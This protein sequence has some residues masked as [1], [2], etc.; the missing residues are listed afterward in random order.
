M[1][2]KCGDLI[3]N[4]N[5]GNNI[6]IPKNT[7]KFLVNDN[8]NADINY[9]INI[10]DKISIDNKIS[11]KRKDLIICKNEE[12]N[13]ETRYLL[14]PNYFIP[15][16]SYVELDENNIKINFVKDF[17]DK[18]SIDNLFWSLFALER[19][20][21]KNNSIILHCS[22]IV[23]KNHAILFS[24]PSGIGKSTQANLWKEYNNCKIIN[25]DRCILTKKNN[26]WYVR[27]L[28]IC[29]SSQ[30]CLN[31]EYKLGNIIFLKQDF[32]N[33][34]TNLNKPNAIKNL[35]NQ[36]TINYWDNQFVSKSIEFATSISNEHNIYE[37]RCTPDINAVKILKNTLERNEKWIL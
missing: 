6:K 37:L 8:A 10:I 3:L 17:I 29:G 30:I 36:L 24:G 15:Y 9:T 22:Y 19:H 35:L 12:K 32:E 31:E 34:I 4:I 1:K 25:G 20:L 21:L 27:S 7:L 33:T 13:L 5:N 11:Y 23:Y 2:I 26:S 28:P 16:A 14:V 18:L